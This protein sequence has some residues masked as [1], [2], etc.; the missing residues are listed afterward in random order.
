[1][2]PPLAPVEAGATEDAPARARRGVETDAEIPQKGEPGFGE[3]TA[4]GRQFE[5]AAPHQT[6]GEPHPELPGEM[7]VAGP[8]RAHRLVARAGDDRPP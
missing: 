7:V 8:R 5:M 6:V 2:Q 3:R 4:L 1:M